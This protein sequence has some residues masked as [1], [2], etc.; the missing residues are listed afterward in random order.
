[1]LFIERSSR[2]KTR[3]SARVS[4]SLFL[5]SLLRVQLR[6][7]AVIFGFRGDL[8]CLFASIEQELFDLDLDEP[9]CESP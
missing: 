5:L 8:L 9:F 2:L 1:L 3:S 4:F 7:F 6:A